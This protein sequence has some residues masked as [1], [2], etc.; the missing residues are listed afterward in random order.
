MATDSAQKVIDLKRLM[1]Q[2]PGVK[3][4]TKDGETITFERLRE[5]LLFWE[6]RV[7]VE[8]GTFVKAAQID[9]SGG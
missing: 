4:I 1:G 9:L 8:A 6:R 7:A 3:S 2:M 5:E